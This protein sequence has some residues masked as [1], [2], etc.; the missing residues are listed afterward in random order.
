MSDP[1]PNMKVNRDIE[2]SRF[3]NHDLAMEDD[4]NITKSNPKIQ[5]FNSLAKRITNEKFS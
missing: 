3:H 5:R 1:N 4:H 2:I